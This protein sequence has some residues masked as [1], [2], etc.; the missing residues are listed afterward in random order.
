MILDKQ[1][2]FSAS[3][4]LTG[5]AVSTNVVDLG[6]AKDNGP[7][8]QLGVA[9][10]VE[11]AFDKLTSLTIDVQCD[12][13]DN[14]PSARTLTSMTLALAD[15]T[16]GRQVFIP[17]PSERVEQFLRLNY[18]VTGT[19]P[20]NGTVSAFLTTADMLQRTFGNA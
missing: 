7:G 12:S 1:N 16:A 8:N 11:V 17:L 6:S 14:F 15:L 10:N 20:D 5:D 18:N 2:Q 4:A 19:D 9:I 3:Q 13:A